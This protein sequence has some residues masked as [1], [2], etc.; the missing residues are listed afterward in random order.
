MAKIAKLVAV[1]LMTRVVVDDTATEEQIWKEAVPRLTRSIIEGGIDNLEFIEDDLEC[2]HSPGEDLPPPGEQPFPHKY[3]T[4]KGEQVLGYQIESAD[5]NHHLP[6]GM[7]SFVV[8]SETA[9]DIWLQI[10]ALNPTG[11]WIKKAVYSGQI[12]DPVYIS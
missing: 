6:A 5:G 2:P 10:D 9:A 8:M 1:S 11:S 3:G 4:P 12:E 7:Y